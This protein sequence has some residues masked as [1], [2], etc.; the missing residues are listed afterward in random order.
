MVAGLLLLL[1]LAGIAAGK[2]RN[3]VREREVEAQLSAVA[4]EMVEAFRQA[5]AAMD[6][7]DAQK[8]ATLFEE[9]VA[10]AP[11]FDP[12]LRRLGYSLIV[13]GQRDKGMAM[14]ESALSHQRSTA[15]LVGLA[16]QLAFPSKGQASAEAKRRALQLVQEA[17][18]KEEDRDAWLLRASLALDLGLQEEFGL[19]L[20][21]CQARFPGEMQTHYLSAIQAAM[22]SDWIRA[23]DEIQ[24]AGQLGLPAEVVRK[25]Q[26]SG[27]HRQAQVWRLTHYALYFLG[28]W[29]LGLVLI[30]VAGKA[31]SAITLNAL[32]KTDPN[33]LNRGLG[34]SFKRV[35]RALI[36]AAG[37]YYYV[38]LPVLI[39]LLI[40]L[41][42]SIFYACLLIGRIPIKLMLILAIVTI[43]TIFQMIRT[44]FL[45]PKLEE[46][47]RPLTPE[48][49]PGLWSL[50]QR[51]ATEV[52][53]RPVDEIRIT[54]GTELAVYERGGYRERMGD[55]ARRVLILGVG[56]LDGFKQHAFSA[57]MAHEYG[58]FAHRDTAGG[59]AALRVNSDMMKF[60]L[61]MIYQGV[62][63]WYNI[64]FHFLR[65]YHLLFR[66]ISHG[67]SRLQ[68]VRAD[69]VA[70][71]HYGAAAF[72]EGLRQAI[73]RSVEFGQVASQ[74]NSGQQFRT[75][76][77]LR[78]LFEP[79]P[80]LGSQ[81]AASVASELEQDLNR[82]SSPDDTHPSPVDRFALARRVQG[83][84]RTESDG[85]V[86]DLFADKPGLLQE[87]VKL[88]AD[89]VGLEAAAAS[90]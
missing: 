1:L 68:E 10:K 11:K 55:K 52:E 19:A 17:S 45:K 81:N 78:A 3:P 61:A 39:F 60:A 79:N 44:L 49:A 65:L 32:N 36:N 31:M 46:P 18:G 77:H 23:E 57:V 70:V 26:A 5:T 21:H 29:A 6:Q 69:I 34:Q 16:T 85:L 2:D 42:G 20:S 13:L 84:V 76:T 58:H 47:G 87:M 88:L 86:W 62:A 4:P 64:A 9:V 72:E 8:A 83:A 48:E 80:S 89:Q 73:R 14:L 53:T 51:V 43:V 66:R 67:A 74:I 35:Y 82:P 41:A 22:R 7:G 12:V 75:R 28:A 54:P 56:V 25:F 90:A 37:L 63:V 59:D 38:S 40:A 30:F 27:V 24:R 15:N 71:Q 50:V 33:E